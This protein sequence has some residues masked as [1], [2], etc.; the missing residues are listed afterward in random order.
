MGDTSPTSSVVSAL[1]D[2][3]RALDCVGQRGL[4]AVSGGVDSLSLLLASVEVASPLGMSIAVAS[5]DHGLRPESRSEV[6]AIRTLCERLR[7]PFHSR[8]LDIA[9]GASLEE[10]ARNQRYKVLEEIRIE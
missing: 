7:V 5:L 10:R 1:T 4:L 2:A 8:K 9:T 6:E 3:Y